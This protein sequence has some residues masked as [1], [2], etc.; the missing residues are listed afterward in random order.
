MS[1]GKPMLIIVPRHS[2][3]GTSSTDAIRTIHATRYATSLSGKRGMARDENHASA[4]IVGITTA[5]SKTHSRRGKRALF[6]MEFIE[7]C[8]LM[9]VTLPY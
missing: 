1:N 6:F 7:V 4:R 9:V 8:W 5:A 3:T 2:G